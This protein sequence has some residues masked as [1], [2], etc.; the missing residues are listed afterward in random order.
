MA[1]FGLSFL[2][3]WTENTWYIINILL[4]HTQAYRDN[5]KLY[6]SSEAK[7]IYINQI[8]DEYESLLY[9]YQ[10]LKEQYEKSIEKNSKKKSN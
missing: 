6:T 5:R 2:T 9:E 3:K 8:L 4:D 1:G 10:T 7:F